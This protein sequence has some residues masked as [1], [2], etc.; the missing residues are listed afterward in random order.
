MSGVSRRT[1]NCILASSFSRAFRGASSA[2]LSRLFSI[3]ASW[4]NAHPLDD[5]NFSIRVLIF[6]RPLRGSLIHDSILSAFSPV[7]LNVPMNRV[8]CA[9]VFPVVLLM[10]GLL[11]KV[12]SPDGLKRNEGEFPPP[13]DP[14][15]EAA[16]RGGQEPG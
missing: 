13:L 9:I 6:P 14:H 16:F 7:I 2:I 8:C 5:V 1:R 11:F 10:H 15:S 3:S 4:L 12:R